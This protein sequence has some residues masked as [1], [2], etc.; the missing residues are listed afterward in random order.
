[1]ISPNNTTGP[2][3]I[4]QLGWTSL[5]EYDL[6]IESG[7]LYFRTI[8][9]LLTGEPDE[10]YCDITAAKHCIGIKYNFNGSSN[11]PTIYIDG[12]KQTL[13][14]SRTR[15][16]TISAHGSDRITL[17]G[18]ITYV[19]GFYHT[20]TDQ[21]AGRISDLFI[22]TRQ[23]TDGEMQRHTFSRLKGF[24][25]YHQKAG[26]ILY[27]PM[28]DIQNVVNI[29]AATTVLPN[30]DGNSL[31]TNKTQ[32]TYAAS[33]DEDNGT[34]YMEATSADDSEQQILDM[35]TFTKPAGS[36]IAAVELRVKGLTADDAQLTCALKKGASWLSGWSSGFTSSL[37][38]K[39]FTYYGDWTQAE[40]VALQ[41][42]LTTPTMDKADSIKVY[43]VDVIFYVVSKKCKDYIGTYHLIG[44]NSTGAGEEMLTYL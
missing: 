44:K 35:A 16:G 26:G 30:A 18:S 5:P 42:G 28:D 23:H 19:E 34:D 8:Y 31:W 36:V 7:R 21:L 25:Y 37:T 12:V 38:L 14:Q 17:G 22:A 20:E 43:Y 11:T 24:S 3:T 41:V 27:C 10:W 40:I 33:V 39:T 29:A 2:M 32:S 13:T 15:D 4:W 6:R 9:N 1:M